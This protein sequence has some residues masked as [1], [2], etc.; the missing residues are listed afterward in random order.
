VK[1]NPIAIVLLGFLLAFAGAGF[2]SID[3]TVHSTVEK[4]PSCSI[5]SFNPPHTELE[6]HSLQ[7]SHSVQGSHHFQKVTGH[8]ASSGNKGGHYQSYRF[9]STQEPTPIW[10][11]EYLT[12]IYPS[13]NFW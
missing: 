1:R 11:K 4:T 9:G 10:T 2:T 7:A 6:V 8:F 5:S 3:K 12:H 13:H